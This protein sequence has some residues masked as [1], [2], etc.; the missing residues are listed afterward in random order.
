MKRKVYFPYYL[1]V[2]LSI[3]IYSC[4]KGNETEFEWS[5]NM[6]IDNE[7]IGNLHTKIPENK[8][9]GIISLKITGYINSVDFE[10]L[11]SL[12]ISYTLKKLDISEVYI[13]EAMIPDNAFAGCTNLEEIILPKID[14]EAIG[15][16]AFYGCSNLESIV[17]PEQTK[18]I[19]ESAFESCSKLCEIK[20][21]SEVKEIEAKAFWYCKSLT[22]LDIP[23]EIREINEYTF[24]DCRA[25][26]EI[27]IPKGIT[28]IE[29]TAFLNCISL[30]KLVFENS[31][32]VIDLGDEYNFNS[33][34]QC[35]IKEIY[36]GRNI[37]LKLF[38][39][40]DS[41]EKVNI[42]GTVFSIDNW[43]FYCKNLK[44]VIIGNSVYEIGQY[45]FISKSLSSIKLSDNLQIIGNMSFNETNIKEIHL[46]ST[47]SKIGAYV[48]EESPNLKKIY[49]Y[50]LTP[51]SVGEGSFKDALNNNCELYVP[52]SSLEKYKNNIFWRNFKN[53]RPM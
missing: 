17:L 49:I 15:I 46:P 9:D 14:I 47:I 30:E 31:N 33:L 48:F 42:G 45:S 20:I 4:H 26:K 8:R 28:K 19:K 53:I 32:L 2:V 36:I 50:N 23:E 52:L 34:F 35:P 12:I 25:L 44:E 7:T 13:F 16:R 10:F 21:P 6:V 11:K 3:L 37:P 18:Y 27:T 40:N 38:N 24:G 29:R 51:P 5:E 39:N 22:T 43:A 41:V 1:L